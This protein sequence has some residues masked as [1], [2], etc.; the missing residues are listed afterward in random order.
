MINRK[1]KILRATCAALVAFAAISARM[2]G[3]DSE[4]GHTGAI[5]VEATGGIGTGGIGESVVN[6]PAFNDF[7]VRGSTGPSGG[8]AAGVFLNANLIFMA[9]LSILGGAHRNYD[10][11]GGYSA[12]TST[13]AVV[14]AADFQ[15]SLLPRSG[16][17]EHSKRAGLTTFSCLIP[18]FEG[19]LGTVQNRANVLV[20]YNPSGQVP[21][22]Q[23]LSG[24]SAARVHQATFAFNGGLGARYYINRHFGLLMDAR[25]FFPTGL[26]KEPFGQFSGDIFVH[27]H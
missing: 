2:E 14:F 13:R 20:P 27:F 7:R 11:G 24:A 19:G 9:N 4:P 12:Q 23:V 18:Y 5:T 17:C 25:G 8:L 6:L 21:Q 26:V 16:R 3:Q 15:Y 22:G 1:Q 10:L